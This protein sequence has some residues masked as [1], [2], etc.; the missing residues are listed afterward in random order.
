MNRAIL[1]AMV[2]L[3]LLLPSKLKSQSCFASAGSDTS[4]CSGEGS[5]YRVYLDGSQSF[6]ENGP[7]NY[8]WTVLD[9]EYLLVHPSQM[10]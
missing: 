7:V 9:E 1:T 6:V 10:R 5:Q 4:V 3:T 8:E 2:G